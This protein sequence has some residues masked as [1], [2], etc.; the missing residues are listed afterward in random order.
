MK[1]FFRFFSLL[2]FLEL[3]SYASPD[4]LVQYVNKKEEKF[5]ITS[6]SII[7]KTSKNQTWLIEFNSLNWK[8]KQVKPSTWRHTMVLYIPQKIATDTALVFIDGGRLSENNSQIDSTL[9]S[10][11][12]QAQSLVAHLRLVPNQG[13]TFDDDGQKRFEDDLVAL[14]WKKAIATGD[15][16][17][18]AHF[19]MAKSTILA[20]NIIENFSKKHKKVDKFV[21]AGYSKRGWAAWLTAM[22]DKRVKGVIPVVIDVGNTIA[23]MKAHKKTLGKWSEAI[24]DYVHHGITEQLNKPETVQM[25]KHIDPFHNIEHLKIPKLILNGANDQ[26]FLPDSSRFYFDQLK[27]EKYLRYVPNY[28]HGLYPPD[29]GASILSFFKSVVTGTPLAK[30]EW[31]YQ[32]ENKIKISSNRK[33]SKVLIWQAVNDTSPDF[34]KMDPK[35]FAKYEST[36]VKSLAQ[37]ITVSFPKKGFKA[38]F[39]EMHFEPQDGTPPHKLTT[40]ARVIPARK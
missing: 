1:Y 36:E 40:T 30:I 13:L 29:L 31:A 4:A 16:T 6:Q 8:E 15:P 26:F 39:V 28:G 11:S 12:D 25:L 24:K 9:Q 21:V 37:T 2:L 3:L 20:M 17:W 22:V 19:P 23:S 7:Q 32:A 5:K 33:P 18:I 10:L 27:G 38:W 35:H 14:S 34:R